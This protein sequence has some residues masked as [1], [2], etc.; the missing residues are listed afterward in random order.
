MKYRDWEDSV[1]KGVAKSIHVDVDGR[2]MCKHPS[3]PHHT[4]GTIRGVYVAEDRQRPFLFAEVQ[5]T[6]QGHPPPVLY[7]SALFSL[8]YHP[9]EDT[10]P[11]ENHANPNEIGTISVQVFVASSWRRNHNPKNVY[12]IQDHPPAVVDER[13]KKAT[14]HCVS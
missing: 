3:L 8:R 7:Y 5:T 10:V 11:G 2:R 12:G 6:G 13:A 4:H 1:I 9:D 14:D